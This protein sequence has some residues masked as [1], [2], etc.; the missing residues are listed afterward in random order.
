M[1]LIQETLLIH[2]IIISFTTATFTILAT[3][4]MQ[5]LR[6]VEERGSSVLDWRIHNQ[7]F[8]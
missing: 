7:T 1:G 4:N 8:N 6:L 5:C 2:Y 3:V